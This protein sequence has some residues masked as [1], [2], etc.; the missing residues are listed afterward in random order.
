ML[1]TINNIRGTPA[2][3]ISF[4]TQGQPSHLLG[5]LIMRFSCR[6]FKISSA[7]WSLGVKVHLKLV[8]LSLVQMLCLSEN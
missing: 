1:Y 5:D 6:S 2:F 4:S 8:S 3:L 7:L